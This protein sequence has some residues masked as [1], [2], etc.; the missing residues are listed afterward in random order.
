MSNIKT[1]YESYKS[2][3]P[4]CKEE[5]DNVTEYVYSD[6]AG[7]WVKTD[8][9]L[10]KRMGS[11]FGH[12]HPH[13]PKICKEHQDMEMRS[14]LINYRFVELKPN[15]C[16]NCKH[17]VYSDNHFYCDN[18]KNENTVHSGWGMELT[19]CFDKSGMIILPICDNWEMDIK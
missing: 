2:Q 18:P 10:T 9:F 15:T 12:N 19:D 13:D 1:R 11:N 6:T 3:C 16:V 8:E 4:H 17:G 14:K 7:S 5:M